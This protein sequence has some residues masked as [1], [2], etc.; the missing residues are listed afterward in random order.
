MSRPRRVRDLFAVSAL[1]LTISGCGGGG[2]G[3][4]QSTPTP[5]PGPTPAPTPT[6]TSP[7][8]TAEYQASNSAT[9]ANALAAYDAGASGQNVKVAVID[10][11][12]NPNLPEFI[13]RVDPASQDVAASRGI[14]D[15]QGHG[16]MVSGVIAANRDGVYMH[17][18]APS[19]SIISLN[20]YDP[21]GCKPGNDCFLDSAIDEA[22]DLAR[23]NGAKIINMSFGDEEGM[24]ADVWPAIQRAV[25]AGIVIVMAAGNSGIADP[26]SFAMTN[27]QQNGASGLFIIAGAMDANRNIAG[28]SNRAGSGA[29]YYLTAL[30]VGNA[31]VNQFGAHVTP[32]G[33]S[34][35]TPTI[36]GAAALLAGAFPNLTG[37]QIVNLLLTTA[38]DPGAAGTDSIFGRG[39]LNIAR[40]FQPQGKTTLAGSSAAISL[41][42]NGVSSGPIGDAS[43]RS[44]TGAI[45][46]DGYSRAYALDLLKT[47]AR[48]PQDQPLRQALGSHDYQS[49]TRTA[50][51]VSV[52]LRVRRNPA[53]EYRAALERTWLGIEE[54]GRARTVAG[55]AVT[56]ITPQTALAFGISQS[57]RALQQRLTK[58]WGRAFLVAQD[59]LSRAGF[60]ADPARS[61]GMRHEFGALGITATSETGR[62]W[63]WRSDPRQTRPGYSVDSITLDGHA[64]PARFSIGTSRLRESRT[65]LGS[66][67]AP[68]FVSGGSRTTFLDSEAQLRLAA[69]GRRRQATAEAG[70]A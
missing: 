23:V 36:A 1:A 70:L 27:V 21:A 48:Q 38:D 64:G 46:L 12:I 56:R 52:T 6:P 45:I 55:L 10:T 24:T 28:F 32:S 19:A 30:G 65:M 47:L 14:V 8:N 34:F 22:I 68:V 59:P 13:G 44:G 15:N 41:F 4:P 50:G 42:D 26:N 9:T 35:A 11:G 20:V 33:T 7:F 16:S 29:A 53:G 49:G 40:A 51:P 2:G 37:S 62:Q 3:G 5:P 54:A 60:Y 67:F 43:S 69:A 58:Q 39:I 18:V 66:R 17:G 25:D 61:V 63:A 57:A 31:T